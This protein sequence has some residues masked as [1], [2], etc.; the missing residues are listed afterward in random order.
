M[1][2]CSRA[3]PRREFPRFQASRTDSISIENALGAKDLFEDN[4]CVIGLP[5]DLALPGRPANRSLRPGRSS[6]P[7]TPATGHGSLARCPPG[8]G[9]SAAVC[10][11]LGAPRKGW[12]HDIPAA[13]SGEEGWAAGRNRARHG[14]RAAWNG[15]R[16]SDAGRRTTPA[17]RH[18]SPTSEDRRRAGR[19]R[20]GPGRR[21]GRP[22]ATARRSASRRRAARSSSRHR[23]RPRRTTADNHR[24]CFFPAG[25]VRA[26]CRLRLWDAAS[27]AAAGGAPFGKLSRSKST[28]A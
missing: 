16:G 6:P 18:Q 19:C 12:R 25:S 13:T 11:C 5:P 20:A 4:T 22:A 10:G 8:P 21:S 28:T 26:A 7:R 3:S 9:R 24:P 23:C 15:R 27:S 14:N 1:D 2:A 17:P